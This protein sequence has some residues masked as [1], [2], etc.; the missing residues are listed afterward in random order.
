MAKIQVILMGIPVSTDADTENDPVVLAF[1]DDKTFEGAFW[2]IPQYEELPA[3]MLSEIRVT[4]GNLQVLIQGPEGF[5]SGPYA[6]D[7]VR[8]S[9]PRG[10]SVSF[11]NRGQ[12]RL[13][14]VS[15]VVDE[16]ALLVE[17]YSV[18]PAPTA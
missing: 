12:G 14:G 10:K 8:A 2:L 5:Q 4:E 17:D 15:V 7:W 16:G 3:G 6:A 11:L 18:G 1:S 9:Y 13:S